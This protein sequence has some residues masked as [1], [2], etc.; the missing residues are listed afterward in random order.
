[1]FN[2]FFDNGYLHS[3]S[4]YVY[5]DVNDF[6]QPYFYVYQSHRQREISYERI[7]LCYREFFF[8]LSFI[9]EA[10]TKDIN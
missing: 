2:V 5:I 4:M 3:R 9:N 7:S 1:M 6:S 8:C 10:W